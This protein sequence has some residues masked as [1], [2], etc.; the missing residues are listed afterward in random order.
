MPAKLKL[1]PEPEPDVTNAVFANAE[2]G[3]TVIASS[4]LVVWTTPWPN[5]NWLSVPKVILAAKVVPNTPTPA[6]TAMPSR[7]LIDFL[8]LGLGAS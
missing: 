3:V 6:I 1:P 4:H 7:I 2:V 5:W 8:R